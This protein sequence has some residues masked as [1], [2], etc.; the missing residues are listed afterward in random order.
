[1]SEKIRP[2]DKIVD[3]LLAL[4]NI[5]MGIQEYVSEKVSERVACNCRRGE[6][7]GEDLKKIIQEE[8][9]AYLGKHN[10]VTEEELAALRKVVNQ[11]KTTQKPKK[12]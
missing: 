2:E 3:G 5:A 4:G 7:G 1:M 6:S 11:L 9:R 12:K 10:F 8:I